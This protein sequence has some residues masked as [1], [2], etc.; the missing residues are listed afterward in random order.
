MERRHRA[1]APPLNRK[2]MTMKSSLRALDAPTRPSAAIAVSA[3][4]R[5][6]VTGPVTKYPSLVRALPPLVETQRCLAAQIAAVAQAVKDEK[7][8]RADID[9]LLVKAGLQKSDVVT[10]AGY[11]VRHNEKAGSTSLNSDKL[12]EQLVAAGVDREFVAQVLKDCTETGEPSKFA[13]VTPSK[14]ATVQP[15]EKLRMA[16]ALPK[17]RV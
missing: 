17:R 8:L 12:T 9:V 15:P 5:V 6:P 2:F 4:K 7:Q 1:A 11:D 13:T 16:K 3:D 10:C 14:G